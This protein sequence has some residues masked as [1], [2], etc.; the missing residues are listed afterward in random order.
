MSS[1]TYFYRI[2][3][4]VLDGSGGVVDLD[5]LDYD[6]QYCRADQTVPDWVID[7]GIYAACKQSD[8]DMF[9]LGEEL[10]GERPESIGLRSYDLDTYFFNMP[11]G[12]IHELPRIELEPHYQDEFFDAYLYHRER[13]GEIEDTYLVEGLEAFD[14]RRVSPA[15][16]RK[17]L[18]GYIEQ[19]AEELDGDYAG[20]YYLKPVYTLVKI[21]LDD[22]SVIVC[23]IS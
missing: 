9:K 10:F 6:T 11:D 1:H 17:L 14:F 3:A 12:S 7:N 23:D 4:P 5:G 19:Y 18:A 2:S 8:I 21:M 16:A 15:D 13:V 20:E 22:E